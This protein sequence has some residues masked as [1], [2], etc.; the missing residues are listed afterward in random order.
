LLGTILAAGYR[1]AI[2]SRLAGV[3]AELADTARHGVANAVAAGA[4]SPALVRAAQ[5]SFVDGW[6]QA[7]W[8]GAAVLAVAGV[9]LLVRGPLRTTETTNEKEFS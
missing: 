3:P 2:S 8:A 6:Q 4:R 1:D 7:M 5:Q 9:Y